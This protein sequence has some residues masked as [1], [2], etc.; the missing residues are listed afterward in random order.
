MPIGVRSGS[1]TGPVTIADVN[2]KFIWDVVSRI[3]I[4]EKGKAYAVDSNGFL[5]ADPDIGLVLRKTPMSG[6]PHVKA[7]LDNREQGEQTMVSHDLSGTEELACH[8]RIES[9]NWIVFAEQPLAEATARLTSSVLQTGLLL[10]AGLVISALCALALAR[11]MVR[12][13]RTLADGAQRIG[14]GDLDQQ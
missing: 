4:G 11:G 12:P 2:L 5:V 13:I 7:A 9:L 8:A 10:L 14:E 6:L 3:K 1:D